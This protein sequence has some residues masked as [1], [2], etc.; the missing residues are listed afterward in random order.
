MHLMGKFTAKI[1]LALLINKLYPKIV[2]LYC[3]GIRYNSF[4]VDTGGVRMK[5]L[6]IGKKYTTYILVP[7][8]AI[9]VLFVSKLYYD[10]K[11]YANERKLTDDQWIA[12]IDKLSNIINYDMHAFINSKKDFNNDIAG[13]KKNIHKLSDT[14]IELKL[15]KAVASIGDAHTYLE[16][17]DSG[18][19]Y[20]LYFSWFGDELRVCEVSNKQYEELLGEKLIKINGIDL[21]K[22]INKIKPLISYETEQWLKVK[23]SD[24]IISPD[25]LKYCGII[26]SEKAIWT[27]QDDNGQA[28]D[29]EIAPQGINESNLINLKTAPAKSISLSM[30]DD[31]SFTGYWY[32][33]IPEDKILY[34]QYNTCYDRNSIKEYNRRDQ[35]FP[36]SPDAYPDFNKFIEGLN[37]EINDNDTR[38]LVIDMRKNAGGFEILNPFIESLRNNEKLNKKGNILI[39]TGKRT[40]SAAVWTCIEIKQKLNAVFIGEP[41]GGIVNCGSKPIPVQLQNSKLSLH[42]SYEQYALYKEYNGSINPDIEVYLDFHDYMN[43]IDNVYETAK[44]YRI[45]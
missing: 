34:F 4:A 22:I 6:G 30:P 20:P 32:K 17:N 14:E 36:V 9:F 7:V 35:N 11:I 38:K 33:Y 2:Y 18:V 12:D 27:F 8:I 24:Y 19:V 42:Y 3:I 26:K 1:Y 16:L 10:N 29:I 45:E 25:V 43:G 28:I 15:T 5:S 39:L 41:T 31:G 40:F 37:K 44:N 13:I 21:D 23:V